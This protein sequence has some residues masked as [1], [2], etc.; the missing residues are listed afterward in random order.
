MEKAEK[1]Q[2]QI[3]S[4]MYKAAGHSPAAVLFSIL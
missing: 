4:A 3:L 2:V 1:I